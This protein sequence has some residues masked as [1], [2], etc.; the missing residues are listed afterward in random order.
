MPTHEIFNIVE[1]IF[2]LIEDYELG[3]LATKRL[4]ENLKPI[5]VAIDDL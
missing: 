2:D 4:N 1:K 3:E 5:D